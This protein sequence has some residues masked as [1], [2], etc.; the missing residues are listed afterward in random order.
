MYPCIY[1]IV[2]IEQML[3]AYLCKSVIAP[4]PGSPEGPLFT[5]AHLII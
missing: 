3:W 5:L 4:V 2:R 1:F